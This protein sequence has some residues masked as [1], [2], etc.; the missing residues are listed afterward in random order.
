MQEYL[1]EKYPA[2]YS[3]PGET[4]IKQIGVFVQKSKQHKSKKNKNNVQDKSQDWSNIIE[5]IVQNDK[6]GAPESLYKAFVTQ[7]N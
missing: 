6:L 7:Y 1:L 5:K 4:E 2:T 3:L